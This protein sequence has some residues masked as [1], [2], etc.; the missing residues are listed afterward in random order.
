MVPRLPAVLQDVGTG[1]TCV[2]ERIIKYGLSLERPFVA[3]TLCESDD[4]RSSPKCLHRHW[5]EGIAED[6]TN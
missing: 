3:A 6:V 1:A 5:A 2:F 4:G